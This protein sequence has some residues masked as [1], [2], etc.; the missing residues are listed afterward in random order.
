VHF[1]VKAASGEGEESPAKRYTLA[2]RSEEFQNA[3]K[4]PLRSSRF[5]KIAK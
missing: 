5:A 3:D 4:A 2:N 1:L